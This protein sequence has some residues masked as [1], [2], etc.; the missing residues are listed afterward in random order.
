VSQFT[1]PADL[2]LLEDETWELI[3]AFEFHVGAFPS[4]D[5]IHVPA[6]FVTDLASIPRPFWPIF[7]P[8]GRYAK[9]AIVHD[10]LYAYGMFSRKYADDVL[11]EGMSVLGV[12]AW[13]KYI[14]YSAVRMFGGNFYNG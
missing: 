4:E 12:P 13:R 8:H 9:A 11:F 14:I 3:R 10:Y 5:V 7:P 2:R 6:G 1:T